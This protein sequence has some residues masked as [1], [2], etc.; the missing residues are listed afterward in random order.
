MMR[1]PCYN[2]SVMGV[3]V[4]MKANKVY[5][6]RAN[7]MLFIILSLLIASPL[8]AADYCVTPTGSGNKTGAD[9]SNALDWSAKAGNTLERGSAYYIAGCTGDTCGVS[10]AAKRLYSATNGEQAITIRKATAGSHVTNTGWLPSYGTDQAVFMEQI[11]FTT[12][13][14]TFDGVYGSGSNPAS[15]GFKIQYTG[16]CLTD[17]VGHRLVGIPGSGYSSAV[18]S[19]IVF[20]H[21]AMPNCGMIGL[22]T[23]VQI[24]IYSNP[25]DT[26]ATALTISNNYLA[27][28][29]SNMA[30]RN[31]KNSTITDN[32]FNRNWS[33]SSNHG[34]QISP[35]S[36]CDDI[37]LKNNIFKDSLLFAIGSHPD[38]VTSEDR[39][40]IY[41]NIVIGG[42]LTAAWANAN[43]STPNGLKNWQIHNNTYV[44]VNFGGRGAVFIGTSNN[45][46]DDKSYAYNNLF[47]NCIAPRLD[48]GDGTAGGIV[49]DYNAYLKCTGTINSADE[50]H[51]QRDDASTDPFVN[52][53]EY[54]FQLKYTAKA[55]DHGID[56][57]S[58]FTTDILGNPRG[59]GYGWDIGAY[60]YPYPEPPVWK[61]P[62]FKQTP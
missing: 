27:D 37:T 28:G 14:W 49:H 12:A 22:G 18:V 19:N 62:P 21:T 24:G 16:D 30:I 9:W 58:F 5:L 45:I 29:S 7:G 42:I 25:V 1:N 46:V 53:A 59:R 52:S 8:F 43:S 17:T 48:N 36:N 35:G 40:L 10:Y 54:D 31:W 4:K 41:N 44:G 47:Y 56:L 15:Y 32:F 23:A 34:Q 38:G 26:P 50:A 60:E 51:S 2:A 20:S 13:Y 39:W 3:E 61:D 55:K 57:S 6:S 33:S 11:N